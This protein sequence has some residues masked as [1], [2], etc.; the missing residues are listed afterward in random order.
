MLNLSSLHIAKFQIAFCFAA[1][2]RSGD[3]VKL[4]A[5]HHLVFV[6]S[7]KLS[8]KTDALVVAASPHH[9]NFEE[10]ALQAEMNICENHNRNGI[11]IV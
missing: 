2:E 10:D 1:Q 6:E 3:I 7:R 9:T 11:H 4:E 8:F 5:W